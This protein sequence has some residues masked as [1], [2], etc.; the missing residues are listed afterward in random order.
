MSATTEDTLLGGAVR[1]LQPVDGYRAAID[2]VLLAASVPAKA[3]DRV[4]ELGSGSGAA[5]LCLA[6]RVPDIHI[7]GLELQADLVGLANHSAALNDLGDR[8]TF[9]AGDVLGPPDDIF[10]HVM[11]N[12]PYQKD[13]HGHPPPDAAKAMANVEGAAKLADWLD[14]A[15]RSVKD[16]GSVTIIHRADRL[17]EILGHLHGQLGAIVVCP[18]WPRTGEVAKRIIVRGRK[19]VATPLTLTPGL[20]LHENGGY[21]D[22]AQAVLDGGTLDL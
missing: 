19:G 14:A 8:V 11:A 16:R 9:I 12:P 7:N 20:V 21:T 17:D 15:V 4:L 22:A 5:S 10:D 2:P 1:L 13:D 18:L 6:C 3:G